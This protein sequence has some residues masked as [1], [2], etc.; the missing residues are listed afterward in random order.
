MKKIVCLFAMLVSASNAFAKVTQFNCDNDIKIVIDRKNESSS[1]LVIHQASWTDI[2][3]CEHSIGNLQRHYSCVGSWLTQ[4]NSLQP[5][6]LN[7]TF[8][9][10]IFFNHGSSTEFF[11]SGQLVLLDGA[12]IP[13]SCKAL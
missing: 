8:D 7:L 11:R 2:M 6:Q 5:A 13:L 1:A 3:S 4:G 10:N 9:L 12:T